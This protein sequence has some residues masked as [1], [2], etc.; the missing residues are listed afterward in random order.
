MR[1]IVDKKNGAKFALKV[2]DKLQS[3]HDS[4]PDNEVVILSKLT[5][6]NII[7]V[8]EKIDYR[9]ELYVVMELIPVSIFVYLRN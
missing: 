8:F 9:N 2:I 3:N 1:L 6:P 5:H 7:L 4:P